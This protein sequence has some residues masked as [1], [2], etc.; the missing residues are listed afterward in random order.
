[1]SAVSKVIPESVKT[2]WHNYRK[3]LKQT[4]QEAAGTD[5]IS[6]DVEAAD[7][8]VKEADER[9]K[10]EASEYCCKTLPVSIF[11]WTDA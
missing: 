5:E 8:G 1:V 10:T 7:W 3:E 2:F 9:Y 6:G 11:Q 4:E